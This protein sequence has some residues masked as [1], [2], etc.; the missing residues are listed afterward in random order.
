MIHCQFRLINTRFLATGLAAT[1]LKKILP[2]LEMTG[3][4]RNGVR[5]C[6]MMSWR[7]LAG[8]GPCLC[9]HPGRNLCPGAERRSCGHPLGRA[10]RSR[11]LSA[12]STLL[13]VSSC[14]SR[15]DSESSIRATRHPRSANAGLSQQFLD[16]LGNLR[17][18]CLSSSAHAQAKDYLFSM[19]LT[20]WMSL[21]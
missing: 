13:P 17:R 3:L 6:I 12:S 7:P 15:P 18:G 11:A 21:K 8:N 20:P 16:F 5:S 2:P 4:E 14:A 9:E 10:A 1:T 19:Y